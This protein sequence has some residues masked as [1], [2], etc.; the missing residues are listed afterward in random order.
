MSEAVLDSLAEQVADLKDKYAAA[1][2][3]LSRVEAPPEFPI[4]SHEVE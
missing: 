1:F 3:A 4:E 2:L